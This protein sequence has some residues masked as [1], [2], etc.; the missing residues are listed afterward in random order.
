MNHHQSLSP[1]HFFK[2]SVLGCLIAGA[3]AGLFYGCKTS[4]VATT[5]VSEP[6]PVESRQPAK[7]PVDRGPAPEENRFVKTILSQDLNEPMELAIASDGRVFLV[8]RSGK[9]YMYDPKS[10]KTRLVHQ[11]PIPAKALSL[12][13][14]G[15]MGVTLDPDFDQNNFIYFF[16][17]SQQGNKFENNLS[18]FR[19]QADNT[20]NLASEKILLHFPIYMQGRSHTG[21][22]LAWDKDK[23]LY[24]STGDDV[25]PTQSKGFAPIDERPGRAHF[26]AQSTSGNTNDLRGKILRIHPEADGSYTIP[27]G[28]LF[29]PGTPGTR[30]EIYVMGC[31]NPYR[32]SVDQQT[33]ILYWGEIGPDAGTNGELGPRGH[34]EFNQAKK[35]GNFG[36]PFFV[37]NNQAYRDY[38]FATNTVGELFR[39]EAP[40]NNSVNNTGLKTLPPAQKAMIWYPYETSP[41]FPALGKG[42]RSAMGGPVYHYNPSLASDKK[43]PAYYDKAWFIFEWMRSWIFVVRLDEQ[44]NFA[45]MEPFLPATGK[46]KRPMDMEIGPDGALYVLDY[47]SVYNADND[48]ACLVR[49][50]FNAG[51]RAPVARIT[52]SDSLGSAPLALQFSS[53]KSYDFDAGDQLSYEWTFGNSQQLSREANPSFTFSENGI[54]QVV[55]KV[56]DPAGQSSRDTLQVKV[57]NTPPQVSITPAS[58]GS[59]YFPGQA[60]LPYTV[61]VKDKEDKKIDPKRVKVQLSYVPQGGISNE[62]HPDN[63]APMALGKTLLETSDCKA[64][65]TL[66]KKAIGPAF[67]EVSQKYQGDKSAVAR[68][69]NKIILG[70]G[71]VWGPNAMNAHPQLSKEEATE[72]IKYV[73]SLATSQARLSLP[74]NGA[75]PLKQHQQTKEPGQYLLTA[76]YTDGGGAITPL[77]SRAQ[78]HLRPARQE[79]EH[80]ELAAHVSKKGVWTELSNKNAYFGL[81]QIDLKDLRQLTYRYA[82]LKDAALELRLDSPDGPVIGRLHLPA[83][84]SANRFT[85]ASISLQESQGRHDLYFVA[86]GAVPEPICRLDWVEFGHQQISKLGN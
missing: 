85:E 55:L 48:D 80:A 41:E 20:L 61:Q 49:V 8:E 60:A 14:D 6:P 70:G 3:A 1:L 76:T 11:F 10:R 68:L 43:L 27:A 74:R 53:S 46:F 63:P 59:F 47:G 54:Y 67:L 17:T 38:D 21:G 65:H 4:P 83:T 28:N 62:T 31:R 23:N 16:Y 40:V 34:D 71:G 86:A 57:G 75:A 82:A 84:G 69:A 79:V 5:A 44:H 15:L 37:G 12:S 52:A 64:C 18:R 26:D 30:P 51:N 33:S 45:S 25:L 7:L 58:N 77:T 19:L 72:I 42:G 73:L 24:L 39:A 50:E 29:A 13:T 78:L 2:R 36:W 9:C 81:R 66:N 22:S 56:S 32:I 35:A